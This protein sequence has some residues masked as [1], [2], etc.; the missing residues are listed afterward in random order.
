MS[1]SSTPTKRAG[2]HEAATVSPPNPEPDEASEAEPPFEP[3]R[4]VETFA[5]HGVEYVMVG[6]MA[7][8]LHGATRTTQDLDCLPQFGADN[9][10]RLAEAMRELRARLRAEGLSDEESLQLTRHLPSPEFFRQGGISNWMTDAGPLDVM[11]DMPDREGHR[12]NYEQLVDRSAPAVHAGITVRI[13]ALDDIVASKEFANRDKDK[14][15]L[16]EL[17]AMQR[18]RHGRCGD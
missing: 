7:A 10:E 16:P 12:L 13:A 8:Q 17:W 6:G 18:D 9:I 3:A 15:A 11:P 2:V 1:P 5:R 4:I 14:D